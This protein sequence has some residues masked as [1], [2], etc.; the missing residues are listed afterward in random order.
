VRADHV[1]DMEGDAVAA[2]RPNVLWICTDQQRFDTLGCYGNTFVHTPN[3][4]RLAAG[5][6]LFEHCYS[7]SPICTPSRAAFLTGRY[8]RTARCPQNGQS[9]PADEVLI[10]RLLAESG[11]TC[12]LAGK[13]HLSACHPSVVKE[14]ERRIADGY[15]EFHWSHHPNPDWEANEYIQWLRAKG[16]TYHTPRY[17]EFRHVMTGMPAELHQT[18][19]CAEKAVEFIR[20]HSD[21]EA[22][23]L[24]S[25]NFFDPH[26]PFDPPAEYLQRYLDRL[27]D[28]PLPNYVEGELDT[29]P[30]RHRRG[31]WVNS[32]PSDEEHRTSRAAYWAMVDLID[33]AVGS[34]M[35]ALDETGQLEST[36][37]IFTSD[38]GEMLGDHGRY[39]KGAY[40]YDPCV[41]V[42]LILFMPGVI[43]PGRRS[44][45]LVELFDLAPT[46]LD[47]CGV[48]RPDGMQARSL[49]P[50]VTGQAPLD[51]HRDDVYCEF[52]NPRPK[53]TGASS[54]TMV[55]T[56]R[57][58]IVVDHTDSLGEL[59]DM[60]ADPGEN[61]NLWDD[62]AYA[63]V[64]AHLLKRVC[65]RMA[66]TVD[67]LPLQES[68]W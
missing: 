55:R 27:D 62:P 52:Y 17:R 59:Y 39:L 25:V 31:G 4:D 9:I 61:R 68:P 30:Q 33:A 7:Q 20:A 47:A 23:W 6:L 5:G 21:G 2:Q 35:E 22:P 32:P 3:V 64:K 10:T 16:G 19:W 24:F 11:Y 66:G 60:V 43:A 54:A 50:M 18:T 37:V 13:L 57:Y 42:P 67:P 28:V 44:P 65:D 53:H 12:G 56:E 46:V 40:F 36:L 14:V 8:P 34:M 51:R 45:A 29:K 41:R 58:K 38:H 48:A 63:D 1:A 26:A 49:W 15:S